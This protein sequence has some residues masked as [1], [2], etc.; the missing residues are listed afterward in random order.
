MLMLA[1]FALAGARAE[2][3]TI[4]VTAGPD[5]TEEVP[6]PINVGWSSSTAEQY[7]F[8]TIKPSGPLG[9]GGSY[10]ADAPNSED[11]ITTYTG[12]AAGTR[13][14]NWTLNAPGTYTLCAFLQTGGS[15]TAPAAASGP[16]TLE[17]RSARASVALTVPPRV[18]A[19]QRFPVV[20]AVTA[21]LERYVFV[22]IKPAG[23]RGCEATYSLDAPNSEDVLSKYVQGTQAASTDYTAPRTNGTY[24]LCAYVQEGGSDPAPEAA[25]SATILVGPDPCVTARASLTKAQKRV[26]T[27]ESAVTRNRKLWKRYDGRAKRAHGARK[28]SLRRQAKK[29]KS[30]YSSAVRTRSK[31]RKVLATAQAGVTAACP[32]G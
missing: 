17:V 26:K 5:P 18:D 29:Y 11:V 19:N 27:A 8:V 13:S 24:L 2:A 32:G 12:A 28:A 22:T 4:S 21:E 14:Q 25:G 9:C 3:D 20:A 30:R 1:L 16:I 10:A 7:A 31:E 6:L 23:G 15:A